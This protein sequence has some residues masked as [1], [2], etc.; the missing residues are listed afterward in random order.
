MPAII[1]FV[2]IAIVTLAV[3][4]FIVHVLF[5]PGCWWPS[6]SWSGSSSAHAAPTTSLG[7]RAPAAA[8]HSH[9]L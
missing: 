9:G 4:A 2:L 8:P 6:P 7:T 5:L 1:A 3:L